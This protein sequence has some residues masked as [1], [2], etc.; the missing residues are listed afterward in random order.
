M[1]KEQLDRIKFYYDRTPVAERPVWYN[2]MAWFDQ[3]LDLCMH[4]HPGRDFGL[5]Q[6]VMMITTMMIYIVITITFSII[7]IIICIII[8][9]SHSV[10]SN[11]NINIKNTIS[12]IINV[13][14]SIITVTIID[15]M[16]D[17][18]STIMIFR[19]WTC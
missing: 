18:I 9:T 10:V 12:I 8:I 2:A 19:T 6:D 16:I 13:I 11:I 5:W 15:S 4:P 7:S 14:G 1:N 17:I 3:Q